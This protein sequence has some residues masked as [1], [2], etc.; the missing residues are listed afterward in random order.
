MRQEL[1]CATVSVPE[2]G[3][4]LGVGRT[5]AWKM[6]KA[7]LLPA[8]RVGWHKVRVPKAALQRM[9]EQAKLPE[10]VGVKA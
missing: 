5:T 4:L 8:V 10:E 2:A 6:V 3:R 1:E 9:L 7:G